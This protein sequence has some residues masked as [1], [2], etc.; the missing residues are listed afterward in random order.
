MPRIPFDD[1]DG[2]FEF[3]EPPELSEATKKA[4][5]RQQKLDDANFI[6][7]RTL[8]FKNEMAAEFERS[9]RDGDAADP[10]F[11]PNIMKFGFEMRSS[12]LSDIPRG[13]RGRLISQDA[14]EKTRSNMEGAM[15]RFSTAALHRL[16]LERHSRAFANIQEAG[17]E[18][19][20]AAGRDARGLQ[21]L[22]ST[23]DNLM[24][25]YEG[26][27]A[28]EE[29]ADQRARLRTGTVIAAINGLIEQG[30]TGFARELILKGAFDPDLGDQPA[31]LLLGRIE[32]TERDSA[33][34]AAEEADRARKLAVAEIGLRVA[35]GNAFPGEI[36]L[37]L[38]QGTIGAGQHARFLAKIE[39]FQDDRARR[40]EGMVR[41]NDLLA[42]REKPDAEDAAD[43]AAVDAL[44]E[45]LA[46]DIAEH[47]PEDRAWI[48]DDYVARTGM[49]PA[50]LRD[51]LLGGMFSEDPAAQVTAAGRLVAFDSSDPTLTAE[52]PD[53]MLARAR[54]IKAFTLPGFSPAR[55]VQVADE[56]IA[57]AAKAAQKAQKAQKTK[58]DTPDVAGKST[59]EGEGGKLPII[60]ETSRK[61]ATDPFQLTPE[62]KERARQAIAIV[63]NQGADKLTREEKIAALK[64][65]HRKP[66]LTSKERSA[67][68]KFFRTIPFDADFV[69]DDAPKR[70]ELVDR[71]SKD[72]TVVSAVKNWAKMDDGERLAALDLALTIYV[73]IYQIDRPNLQLKD[74]GKRGPQGIIGGSYNERT[75]T[76]TLNRNAFIAFPRLAPDSFAAIIHEAGHAYL[77]KL[78]NDYVDGKIDS[79]DPRS[80][81]A[82]IL[83]LNRGPLLFSPKGMSKEYN[84]Q[85]SE[86]YIQDV[87]K[88]VINS[89]E[90][91]LR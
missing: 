36:D 3:A 1:D 26:V 13:P 91:F 77:L 62:Q 5:A 63:D 68:I 22:L 82:L 51:R 24:D 88:Q 9:K 38:A 18:F 78:A 76:I 90:Q 47:P 71:L 33:F 61:P 86:V 57:R 11:E 39:R 32:K 21:S 28:D 45:G 87:D 17:E 43:R 46:E 30:K 44:F 20:K 29:I 74:M 79:G 73:S 50:A 75:N 41:V 15:E 34:K 60:Q 55:T 23:V 81:Q 12:L 69:Q 37:A 65:L 52:F 67:A 4:M 66:N 27:F 31:R 48:E 84:D 42:R 53:D 16:N 85:P 49:L 40:I 6:T 83:A 10:M 8:A 56:M 14:I 35:T 64:Y 80:R 70:R 89:L 59:D 54:A 2:R 25:Q 7:E 58:S 72:Q 19:A